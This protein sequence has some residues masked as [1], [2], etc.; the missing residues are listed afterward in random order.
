LAGAITIDVWT[1]PLDV[2]AAERERLARFLSDDEAARAGRYHFARDRERHV[3]AR[4]RLR[5]I[6][7]ARVSSAPGLLEFA[8]SAHGKPTL[9]A[10]RQ[11]PHFNLSHS[12]GLA[13]LAV[14]DGTELGLDIEAILPLEEDIAGRFFSSS[15]VRALRALPEADRLPGF[16]RCWTRKEAVLK[17]LGDGLSRA[18]DSFDVSLSARA[19]ARI[20]RMDGEPDAPR[21]WTLIHVDPA[22][23]FVGAIALR[24][25]GVRVEVRGVS[26]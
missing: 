6:L 11:A 17:S 23:E 12:H 19:P 7:G 2:G 25:G 14:C 24:S 4:G 21:T 5:E 15:E 20:E 9:A 3:V 13:A 1:W 8:Y 22:E 16:Y 26:G 10:P 18:L